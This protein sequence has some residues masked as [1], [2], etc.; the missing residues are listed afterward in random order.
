MIEIDH[1]INENEYINNKNTIDK[2]STTDESSESSFSAIISPRYLKS[3]KRNKFNKK[4]I[5]DICY[6][7]NLLEKYGSLIVE[8]LHSKIFFISKIQ[9]VVFQSNKELFEKGK[10]QNEDDYNKEIESVPDL[11]FWHQRYYYYTLFDE[12][13]KMD[14]ES[15]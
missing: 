10:K 5:S 14:N 2:D 1:Y 4:K 6:A 12:G 11:S 9:K 3:T 7:L 8:E 13:I 15:K